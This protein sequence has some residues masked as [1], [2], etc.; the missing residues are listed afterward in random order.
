MTMDDNHK[1]DLCWPVFFQI[2]ALKIQH[3]I[4][5]KHIPSN[6]KYLYIKLIN[7]GPHGRLV[8]Y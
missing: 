4:A 8:L 5:N 3:K 2:T 7:R 1:T 6:A